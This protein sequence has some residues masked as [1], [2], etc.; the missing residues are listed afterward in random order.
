MTLD[1]NAT[2]VTA[3]DA[4][5]ASTPAAQSAGQ[6]ILDEIENAG[7]AELVNLKP[8]LGAIVRKFA[9]SWEATNATGILGI[10]ERHVINGIIDA[11]FGPAPT[12]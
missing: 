3:A 10:A 9:A 4:A 7:K 8:L 2:P 5:P 12:T 6:T 11:I 1:P